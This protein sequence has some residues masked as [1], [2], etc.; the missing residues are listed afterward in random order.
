MPTKKKATKR[1]RKSTSRRVSAAVSAA[2]RALR[3]GKS[4]GGKRLGRHAA[5]TR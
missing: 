1:K 3:Q 5:K 4:W 2:A